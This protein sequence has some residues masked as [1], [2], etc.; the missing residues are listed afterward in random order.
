MPKEAK[1][2]PVLTDD[3]KRLIEKNWHLPLK[4]L[5]QL[6]FNDKTLNGHNVEAKAVKMHLAT[7]G[8]TAKTSEYVIGQTAYQLTDEH[9]EYIVNN[10]ANVSG[11]ME[12]VYAL[13]PQ[14]EGMPR[15]TFSSREARAVYTYC[16]EINPEYKREDEPVEE[17]EYKPPVS[18]IHLIGKINRAAVA[19]RQGDKAIIDPEG[20][21][22]HVRRRLDAMLSY[23]KTNIFKVTAD[24]YSRKVDRDLLEDTFI[25]FTWDKEDLPATEMHQ[26]ITLSDL[27]VRDAQIGRQL[28]KIEERY[29]AVMDDPESSLRQAEVELLNSM[30]EKAGAVL[31][32]MATLSKALE[33][34]RSERDDARKQGSATMH[35]LVAAMREAESRHIMVGLANKNKTA[36]KEEVVRLSTMDSILAELFGLSKSEILK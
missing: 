24:K 17:A 22:P 36:L 23:L 6:V 35:N 25:S 21:T 30:R 26:Y 5:V 3:Q 10:V 28:Q 15:L 9:K 27:V 29:N 32:Q 19:P 20:M 34:V 33:G 16:K 2:I 12:L 7:L 31:K 13:F 14:P 1:P 8:K 18:I 4:D 11:P